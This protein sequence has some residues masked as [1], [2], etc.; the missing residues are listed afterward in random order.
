MRCR[1]P[2]IDMGS[3]CI[4]VLLCEDRN[5]HFGLLLHAPPEDEL[6]DPARRRF[7]TAYTFINPDTG[8]YTTTRLAYLGGDL[9]NLTFQNKRV[10]AEWREVY[11]QTVSPPRYHEK[12]THKLSLFRVQGPPAM[13]FR[14]PS[15]LTSALAALGLN[16][17]WIGFPQL[18]GG[19]LH[20]QQTVIYFTSTEKIERIMLGLGLCTA[21]GGRPAH[22]A[23]AQTGHNSSRMEGDRRGEH[24]CARDHIDTWGPR[25]TR[26]FVGDEG[27]VVRLTF[28]PCPHT[29]ATTRLVHIELGGPAYEEMQR[30]AGVVDSPL[31]LSSSELS[32]PAP[33]DGPS[34]PA[35]WG[36]SGVQ[37]ASGGPGGLAR[38]APDHGR[39]SLQRPAPPPQRDY[40]PRRSPE[41]LVSPTINYHAVTYQPGSGGDLVPTYVPQ[42]AGVPAYINSVGS[43]SSLPGGF[44]RYPS[45]PPGL[46]PGGPQASAPVYNGRSTPSY[47]P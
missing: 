30:I 28:R 31:I 20:L 15:W 16:P 7:Y 26:D 33:L 25:R 36:L 12:P 2:I 18:D 6:H 34:P 14:I 21:P 3:Y 5:G 17:T 13:P 8:F 19:P 39:A 46:G 42:D 32:A 41:T 4:A 27:R 47:P 10:R 40:A 29:P 44:Y 1:F 37:R 22:W 45:S 9:Q 43:S 11:I 24:D 35:R 23:W 38:D